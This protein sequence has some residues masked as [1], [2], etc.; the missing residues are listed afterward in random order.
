MK[1]VN[2]VV[3][4]ELRCKRCSICVQICPK[5][6]FAIDSTGYVFVEDL[7]SCIGCLSCQEHCPDLAVEVIFNE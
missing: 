6:V 7:P 5:K 2:D 1:K 4:N 3:I